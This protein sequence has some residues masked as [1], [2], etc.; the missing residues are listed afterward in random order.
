ML[1]VRGRGLHAVG[2]VVGA[3]MLGVGTILQPKAR[4]D[5]HWSTSPKVVLVEE[6]QHVDAG[7]PPSPTER[8]P[9]TPRRW[10]P[11]R[12]RAGAPRSRRGGW[13]R[14]ALTPRPR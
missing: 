2:A 12:R 1:A 7:G 3:A 8:V 11:S 6:G 13:V 5:D 4:L 9:A 10:L 14:S